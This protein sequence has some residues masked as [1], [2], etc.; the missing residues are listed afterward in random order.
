MLTHPPS[1]QAVEGYGVTIKA[2]FE[3]KID[4]NLGAYW[5]ITTQDK[6]YH[7]YSSTDSDDNYSVTVDGCPP[8]APSDPH[9]CNFTV[10]L[11]I[12]SLTHNLSMAHL[13]SS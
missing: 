2:T 3:G 12:K 1:V 11:T 10:A 8:T 9:C 13:M 7:C 4:T 6:S 5:C